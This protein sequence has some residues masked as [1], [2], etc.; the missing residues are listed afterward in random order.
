MRIHINSLHNHIGEE[1]TLAG[2]VHVRRDHGKLIFIDLRDA[3]G[4]VQMVALPNHAEAHGVA[5]TVR[6]EWVVEVRGT[7][8]KRPEKMV[9]PD[10]KNGDIEIELLDMQVFNEAQTPPFSVNEDTRDIDETL[11]LKYRYLD[12][13]TERLAR[14]MR[15]RNDVVR[16]CRNYLLDKGFVE[17]ET[18]LLTEST[19]EGSR[20]FVVPSRLNPGKFYALPQS[21]QQYK[22]LLMVGGMERYFQLARAVRDEDLRA[23]RGFEH[24]QLDIEISFVTEE[25]IRALVEEMIIGAVEATGKTIKEKPFPRITYQEAMETYGADKFDMRTE[26]E[27]E[28]GILAFAW[29]VD[30]PMFEKTDEGTWTFTHNPFSMPKPEHLDM[31]MKGE[32]VEE[33]LAQQYDL[34]CNG[35]ECGGGSIRAH[36]PEILKA[37]YDIMGY[38]NEEREASVGHMLEAFSYGAPPHGGLAIGVERVTM[39]LTGESELREVQ[40]FPMTRGGQT[41]AMNAPKPLTEKQLDELGIEIKKEKDKK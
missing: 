22:Q 37:T 27:K 31:L 15:M 16:S 38:S 26:E 9:N 30:F 36:K 35:Y 7:V 6:S 33:I 21:P 3:S 2:W 17:I 14:N 24:T 11:R 12:L 39:I 19:P 13:R 40:A 8:N 34:V 5:G 41:A 25:E 10:E 28:Q 18:P 1:V 23:D 20:D 32:R 29:V 4:I